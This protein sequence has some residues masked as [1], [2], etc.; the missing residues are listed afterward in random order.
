MASNQFTLIGVGAFSEQKIRI[1]T[2]RCD[3]MQYD[4]IQHSKIQ[5][6]GAFTHM[7]THIYP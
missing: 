5:Y 2:V 6:V 1:D 7:H 4:T 3:A